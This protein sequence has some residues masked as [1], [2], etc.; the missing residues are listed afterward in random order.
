MKFMWGFYIWRIECCDRHLCGV[1][2][3]DHT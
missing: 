1:T 2:G 3:S